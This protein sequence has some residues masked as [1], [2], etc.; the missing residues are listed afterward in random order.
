[1]PGA[2]SS[3]RSHSLSLRQLEAFWSRFWLHLSEPLP[4]TLAHG[5][6]EMPGPW[7]L[8]G[9]AAARGLR[10]ASA[11]HAGATWQHSVSLGALQP[12]AAG[13]EWERDPLP[14]PS[15][16]NDT[17]SAGSWYCCLLR[18]SMAAAWPCLAASPSLALPS[19]PMAVL[20]AWM[21]W[22][23]A[24]PSFCSSC[25]QSLVTS[26]QP[27]AATST[28]LCPAGRLQ[29]WCAVPWQP[30]ACHLCP[31]H[32]TGTVGVCSSCRLSGLYL[33]FLASLA[34]PPLGD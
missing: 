21:V 32:C 16:L 9:E 20:E 30:S 28:L 31:V 7:Q 23:G 4:P 13:Q 22:H 15:P 24:A 5:L 33:C 14:F 8:L 26:S 10:S 27:P 1:M 25:H 2:V 18:C 19:S 11:A 17:A 6:K 12:H 3:D 29:Q 34:Q